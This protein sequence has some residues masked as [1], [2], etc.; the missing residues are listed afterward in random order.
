MKCLILVFV[1][2][3]ILS[4]ILDV[5]PMTYA[6]IKCVLLESKFSLLCIILT[7]L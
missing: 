1:S 6:D 3:G 4:V 5:S 2:V 7:V